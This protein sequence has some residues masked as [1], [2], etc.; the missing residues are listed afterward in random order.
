LG[1][2]RSHSEYETYAG[3]CFSKRKLHPHVVEG[4]P[5]TIPFE[6]GWEETDL[7]IRHKIMKRLLL[8]TTDFVG[9]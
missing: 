7:P 1:T 2:V 6:K 3:I 8:P 5:P 4:I 9:L